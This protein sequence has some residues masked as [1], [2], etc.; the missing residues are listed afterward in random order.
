MF[1]D[2]EPEGTIE[3]P[4]SGMPLTNQKKNCYT[5]VS[6]GENLHVLEFFVVGNKLLAV[7]FYIVK[8]GVD[9]QFLTTNITYL[10]FVKLCI[11][12]A[13][14]MQDSAYFVNIVC[15]CVASGA[16]A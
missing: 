7:L 11:A 3:P 6:D 9:S 2:S 13:L 1:L 14:R 12:V 15:A 16:V 10:L 4:R 8:G 5:V